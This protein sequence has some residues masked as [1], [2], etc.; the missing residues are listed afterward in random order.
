MVTCRIA[1]AEAGL[2]S[3]QKQDFWEVVLACV[4]LRKT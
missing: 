2:P 4:D 3:L 1:Q